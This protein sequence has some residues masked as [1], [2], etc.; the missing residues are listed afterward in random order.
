MESRYIFRGK[1]VILGRSQDWG[2]IRKFGVSVHSLA[3]DQVVRRMA[4]MFTEVQN[5]QMGAGV[6]WK[7]S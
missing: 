4:L 6:G 3:S 2:G 1:D 7:H 5:S